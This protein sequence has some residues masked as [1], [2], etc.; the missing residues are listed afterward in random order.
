[1]HVL[2]CSQTYYYMGQGETK[3]TPFVLKDFSIEKQTRKTLPVSPFPLW[4]DY[5]LP[6]APLIIFCLCT[7]DGVQW[8]ASLLFLCHKISQHDFTFPNGFK[9]QLLWR[10]FLNLPPIP[11]SPLI[12]RA[13]YANTQ[14]NFWIGSPLAPPTQFIQRKLIIFPSHPQAC[15]SICVPIS[16]PPSI[17]KAENQGMSALFL[18]WVH[19]I[20]C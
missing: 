14:L 9:H 12:H 7:L 19:P 16:M 20:Y 8:L 13:V 11:I 6:D 18:A 4:C 5:C 1:M 10:W 15:V 17:A 3:K 2:S